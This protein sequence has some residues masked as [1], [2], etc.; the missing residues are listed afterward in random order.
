MVAKRKLLP[1]PCPI[2]KRENGTIQFIIFRK[3][4]EDRLICRIGHYIPE[5]Y[6]PTRIAIGDKN[7]LKNMPD[8]IKKRGPETGGRVWH[9]FTIDPS[10][11]EHNSTELSDYLEK[12]ERFAES[13]INLHKTSVAIVPDSCFLQLIEENGWCMMHYRNYHGRVREF[14]K[15]HWESIKYYN[16]HQDS[17]ISIS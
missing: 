15:Y 12:L 3:R 14:A 16:M 2:C 11:A 17:E 8:V 1:R 10:L 5:K 9:S 6:K 7:A 4:W 13:P